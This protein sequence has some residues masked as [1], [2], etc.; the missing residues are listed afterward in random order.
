[1]YCYRGII[2][3]DDETMR[4]G[5]G[6]SLERGP[7]RQQVNDEDILLSARVND[8]QQPQCVENVRD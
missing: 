1:M 3:R 2:T 6:K 7:S 4:N 8:P 5:C